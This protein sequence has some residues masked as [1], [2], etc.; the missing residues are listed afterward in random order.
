MPNATHGRTK[1]ARPRYKHS[2]P[3]TQP[4]ATVQSTVQYSNDLDD[5]VRLFGLRSANHAVTHPSQLLTLLSAFLPALH[6]KDQASNHDMI[7]RKVAVFC[8]V[9]EVTL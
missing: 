3:F 7:D 9:G 8:E 4:S 1:A 2:F 5:C 6:H